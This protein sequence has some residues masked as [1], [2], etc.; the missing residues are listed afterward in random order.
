MHWQLCLAFS[1][2]DVKFSFLQCAPALWPCLF[3]QDQSC[4]LVCKMRWR[5]NETC[6]RVT[7][8]P[9]FLWKSRV[10]A[11]R[12]T[13][14][15]SVGSTERIANPHHIFNALHFLLVAVP[16]LHGSFLRLLQRALQGL[17]P[18]GGGPQTFLQFRELT[19]QIRIV[20]YQLSNTH[21]SACDW[22]WFF[23]HVIQAFAINNYCMGLFIYLYIYFLN[24][25][26]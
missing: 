16:I 1:I 25:I 19:S 20:V 12:R 15:C 8:R 11:Q 23:N 7:R 10:C 21:V 24:R 4:W 14:L 2:I 3:P 9:R 17:D 26:C 5:I 22:T 6:T 13:D 18:F